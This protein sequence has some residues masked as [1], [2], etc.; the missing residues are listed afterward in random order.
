MA[1]LNLFLSPVVTPQR[2][3]TL[4]RTAATAGKSSGGS[5]EEK[6]ILDFILGG[7]TKQDQFY[8]TDPILKKVEEKSGGTTSAGR[9]NSAAPPPKKKDGGFVSATS[10]QSDT[11]SLHSAN[12]HLFRAHILTTG[13]SPR[14]RPSTCTCI[15]STVRLLQLVAAAT[16]HVAADNNQVVAGQPQQTTGCR[17]P[18]TVV[19]SENAVKKLNFEQR[20]DPSEMGEMTGDRGDFLEMKK[21]TEHRGVG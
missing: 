3:V 2:R 7:L 17:S 18:S 6:S 4:T 9:K 14:S 8:E 15:A 16:S 12:N 20:G 19:A 11:S 5:S 10:H 13:A 1:S 21:T